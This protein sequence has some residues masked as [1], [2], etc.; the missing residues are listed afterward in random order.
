MM[1]KPETAGNFNEKPNSKETEA[2]GKVQQNIPI[3]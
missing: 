2:K 1:E 3:S